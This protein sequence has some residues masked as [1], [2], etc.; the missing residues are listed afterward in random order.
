MKKMI[1]MTYAALSLCLPLSASAGCATN[2][3]DG[4]VYCGPGDCA[5][6]KYDNRVYC[7]AY[8]GGGAATNLGDGRVYCGTGQNDSSATVRAEYCVLAH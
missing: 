7:S 3:I 6:N 4:R 5:V 1:L 2:P 8:A